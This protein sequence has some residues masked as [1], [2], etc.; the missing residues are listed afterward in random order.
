MK[1]LENIGL[2][3]G[4]DMEN[5]SADFLSIMKPAYS[6]DFGSQYYIISSHCIQMEWAH[7]WKNLFHVGHAST[8]KVA[9][10]QKGAQFKKKLE[11]SSSTH[12]GLVLSVPVTCIMWLCLSLPTSKTRQWYLPVTQNTGKSSWKLSSKSC[13]RL[14]N[15]KHKTTCGQR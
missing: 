12:L 6:C 4:D 13:S 14:K 5:W 7:S 1:F 11:S 15:L 2:G 9:E 8:M 3:L 10:S